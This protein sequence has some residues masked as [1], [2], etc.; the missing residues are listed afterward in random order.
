MSGLRSSVTLEIK[1]TGIGSALGLTLIDV[2]YSQTDVI[3]DI[4]LYDAL[5]EVILIGLWLW[6][7]H[8]GMAQVKPA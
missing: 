2:Y 4:Y 8:R 5:G 1:W 7:G 6:A 3:S